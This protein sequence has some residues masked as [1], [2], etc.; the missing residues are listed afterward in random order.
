MAAPV[1]EQAIAPWIMPAG[2]IVTAQSYFIDRILPDCEIIALPEAVIPGGTLSWNVG[3]LVAEPE[4]RPGGL[5]GLRRLQTQTAPEDRWVVDLRAHSPA[6]WAHFLNGHLPLLF[7]LADAAQ[8]DLETAL[9]L[10]PGDVPGYIL[11]LAALFGIETLAT[12]DVVEGHGLTFDVSPWTATRPV[13]ADWVRLPAPTAAIEALEAAG[14]EAAFPD[15]VFLARR[16]TRVVSNMDEIGPLL[17]RHG[18]ETV[19]PEDLA[20]ADQ[21]SLFCQATEMIAVHG[22]GLAPLLF[23]TPER[24]LR[25]LVEILP[26]GHMTNVYRAMAAQVGC[27]WVGVRGRLKPEYVRPAYK[28]GTAFTEYSLDAFEVDP[29]SLERALEMTA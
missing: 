15:K 10:L 24:G 12:D 21:I 14:S 16:K 28:I 19:Y 9:A 22:A 2:R 23:C 7:A 25:R 27:D 5:R 18:F 17:A 20:P 8:L 3:P 29:V 13:R 11:G 4:K 6:N 1:P 26:V